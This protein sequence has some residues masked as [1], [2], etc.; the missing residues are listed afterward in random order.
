M[1]RVI[2]SAL[3]A[4][5][6]AWLA[7]CNGSPKD[8][9]IWEKVKITDLATP[10]INEPVGYPSPIL[11]TINFD[12]YT[13]HLPAENINALDNIL[14]MLY[15]KPLWFNNYDAFETNCFAA[16]FGQLDIWDKVRDLLVAA[17][18]EKASGTA[19]MLPDG[20]ANRIFVT[21][22]DK[23]Q[24][25][26]YSRTGDSMEA[27]SIGPGTM[28]LRLQAEKIAGLRGQCQVSIQPA[29]SPLIRADARPE[30]DVQKYGDYFFDSAGFKLRMS[31]G[32]FVLLGPKKLV[33]NR[34]ILPGL[35]FTQPQPKPLIRIFLIICT[36]INL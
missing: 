29:Y 25:V 30:Q 7:G 9:P 1:A 22:L 10:E 33:N 20:Q 8:T 14:Q 31:G 32:D 11:K 16:G 27:V 13:F 12:V 23:E 18:A 21:R 3:F 5:A 24:S 35:F 6:I 34:I 4:A 17:G 28:T 36:A 19:V 26:F 15:T 2:K